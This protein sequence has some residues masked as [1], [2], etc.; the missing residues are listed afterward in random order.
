MKWR[1]KE[2]ATYAD[3]DVVFHSF[4]DSCEVKVT[5]KNIPSHDEHGQYVHIENIQNGWRKNIF[6]MIYKVFGYPLTD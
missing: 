4:N 2:W 6:E 5:M 3:V 1:F